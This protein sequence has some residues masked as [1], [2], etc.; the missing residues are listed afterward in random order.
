MVVQLWAAGRRYNGGNGSYQVGP[1][2]GAPPK[3]SG[4]LAGGKLFVRSRPQYQNLGAGNFL[5]ATTD[6]GIS[7]DGIGDQTAKINQFL[8][9]AQSS[10]KVAYFPAGIYLCT[11]TVTIP[12]GS[13]VQGSSWSQVSSHCETL[14]WLETLS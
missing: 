13:R 9:N 1:V 8:Q 10:G 4:L 6:G 2:T 3:P 5:V 12:T 7:N 11:G 14:E